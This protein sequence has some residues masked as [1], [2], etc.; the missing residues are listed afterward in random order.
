M[1]INI[2]KLEYVQYVVFTLRY[3]HLISLCLLCA[4]ETCHPRDNPQG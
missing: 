1:C 2:S 3:I 4:I